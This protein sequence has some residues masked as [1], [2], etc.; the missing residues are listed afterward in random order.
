MSTYLLQLGNTPELSRVELESLLPTA[1]LTSLAENVIAV[2]LP[3]DEAANTLVDTSGGLIKAARL[4][5]TLPHD[6]SDEILQEKIIEFLINLDLKKFKFGLAEWGRDHLEALSVASVKKELLAQGLKVRYL[7]GPRTGLSSSI[8]SHQSLA[9]IIVF[10]NEDSI[11]LALTVAVQD[12]DAWTLRDRGKPYADRRKGLLP[13]K[14]ARMMVNCALGGT[15][16]PT[17]VLYDPFCGSGTVLIEALVRGSHVAGSDL[18]QEASSGTRTNIAWMVDRLKLDS[19]AV[20]NIFMSDATQV[21][22]DRIGRKVQ[23]IVTEPFLGKPTPTSVQ[24]PGIFKGLE[25]LYLGSFK[26]W[27]RILTP[28]ATIVMIFPLVVDGKNTY[29]LESLIDKLAPFGYTTL[30]EPVVYHRPQAIVQRQIH[31]L[32]FDPR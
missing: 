23:Y 32:K 24:L 2:E 11:F 28:G 29:S 21:T 3:D 20:G 9:E 13:P 18:D 27:T 5:E 12:I 22:A 7:E 25:K 4:L 15:D 6:T 17:G 19:A 31:F 10:Q 26:A 16:K 14:V 30:H 1:E 8:L